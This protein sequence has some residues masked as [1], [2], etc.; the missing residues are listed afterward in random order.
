M[1][2]ASGIVGIGVVGIQIVGLVEGALLVLDECIWFVD[3]RGCVWDTDP[4]RAP[5]QL[6]DVSTGP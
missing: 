6:P 2:E 4:E 1:S 3:A 5:Q